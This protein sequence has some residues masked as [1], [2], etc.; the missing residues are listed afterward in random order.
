LC[1]SLQG[2]RR[3]SVTGHW[4]AWQCGRSA[5]RGR[6]VRDPDAG[7]NLSYALAGRSAL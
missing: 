3:R 2:G 6:T 5:V 4:V 1:L 7:A